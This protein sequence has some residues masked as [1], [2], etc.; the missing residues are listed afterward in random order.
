MHKLMSK[1]SHKGVAVFILRLV[2]GLVFLSHG[3]EKFSEAFSTP[4]FFDQVQIGK[5]WF[6]IIASIESVGGVALIVG[7]FT[8][9]A[10][11]LVALMLLC[12]AIFLELPFLFT[13]LAT[14]PAEQATIGFKIM[15][16]FGSLE[17][18]LILVAS[19]LILVTSGSGIWSLARW[20]KCRC[21]NGENSLLK[22]C[23]V[24]S[25]VGCDDKCGGDCKSC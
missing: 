23:G 17:M 6:Y 18:D 3:W 12:Q 20:C 24:C 7:L 19:L 16:I 2:L 11:S 14:V 4:G 21:H 22:K 10:S 1:C 13:K 8:R 9:Y 5:V 25:V 15:A